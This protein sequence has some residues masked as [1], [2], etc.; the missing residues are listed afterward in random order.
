[1]TSGWRVW[2]VVGALVFLHFLL[3]VGF[4][5]GG[6]APDLLTVALLIGSREVALGAG[7]GMGFVFGLLEDAFSVLGFGA[8][9]IT[10][11][12]AGIV[13]SLTRDL[14]VGDSLVFLV[15][16]FFLGKWARDGVHW[17]LVGDEVRE[18]FVQ[19]I[20]IDGALAAAY[21]TVVGLGAVVVG[22]VWRQ[23]PG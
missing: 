14:F 21:A 7:A 3:H 1:M 4:G 15:S 16:Y 18:P 19:A 8:N 10:M 17:V 11:T 6:E 5:L 12:L 2:G 13:G 20:L 23:R 9:V 22:G